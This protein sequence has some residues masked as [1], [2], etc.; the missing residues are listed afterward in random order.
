MHQDT[1]AHTSIQIS[2]RLVRGRRFFF[3]DTHVNR[4]VTI[5]DDVTA[6]DQGVPA[7]AHILPSPTAGKKAVVH[8]I[9]YSTSKFQR[10]GYTHNAT[11]NFLQHELHF[12]LLF[13]PISVTSRV[14]RIFFA[15]HV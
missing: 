9:R 4:S 1:Q 11:M 14:S 2:R 15:D 10:D 13:L 8:R 7:A 3:V 6:S 12:S 5:G